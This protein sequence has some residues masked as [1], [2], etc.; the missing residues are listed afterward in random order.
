MMV[1]LPLPVCP[2]SAILSHFLIS[3]SIL[4]RTSRSLDGY[5]NER[6]WNVTEFFIFVSFFFHA[7][8]S[9]SIANMASIFS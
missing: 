2:M 7:S 5:E 3:K 4:E 8:F 6:F 1:D 9:F